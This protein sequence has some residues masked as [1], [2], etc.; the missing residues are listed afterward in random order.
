VLLAVAVREVQ[1]DTAFKLVS[2]GVSP[3]VIVENTDIFVMKAAVEVK[4]GT[5]LSPCPILPKVSL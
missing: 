3:G 5:I 2:T 4:Y 1:D